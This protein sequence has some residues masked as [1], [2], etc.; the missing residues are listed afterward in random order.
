MALDADMI[1]DRRRLKRK[2][3]FWRVGAVIVLGILAVVL[4]GRASDGVGLGGGLS[5]HVA[6]LSIQGVILDDL[7][8]LSIIKEIEENSR[9][10]AVMVKINSPGGTFTGGEA[11]YEALRDLSQVKPVVALM[12]GTATSAG[13]MV[14]L[15]AHR[16]F[17]RKGT[18]TGSIGVLIQ[19]ADVTQLLE[20]IG[21][22][23]QTF[24]SGPLKAQ[25]NPF[26]SLSEEARAATQSVL[27]DLYGLFVDMV[28]AH[29]DLT[30]EQVLNLADGRIFTGR[31]AV[32]SGLVDDIGAEPEALAWLVAERDIREGLPL[33]DVELPGEDL[34]WEEALGSTV[35]SLLLGKS[36]ISERLKLDGVISLWHPAL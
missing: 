15:P 26:E 25:P 11:L 6:R 3:T 34:P 23:P 10:K 18:I 27:D 19:T 9:A 4:A 7:E 2:L 22:E 30:R 17:A 35:V 28:V 20:N 5:E 8:L 12:D 1:V 29:R 36:E 13:Y 32:T 16:L 14:A 33:L 31:Q 24:K 21:I